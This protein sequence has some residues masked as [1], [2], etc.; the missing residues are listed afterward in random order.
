MIMIGT[1]VSEYKMNTADMN[2]LMHLEWEL[3]R[4]KTLP[5]EI[6]NETVKQWLEKRIEEIKVNGT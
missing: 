3:S 5:K 4:L 2:R 6:L 1:N